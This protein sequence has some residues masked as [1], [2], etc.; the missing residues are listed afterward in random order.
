MSRIEQLLNERILVLDG[1]MGSMVQQFKLGEADYRGERFKNSPKDLKG[2]NDLLVL[3]R[4]DIIRSIHLDYL[5]AGADLIETNTFN[6]TS[7]AQKD[8]G[9]E[10]IVYEL[11]KT[12]AALAKEACRLVMEEAK[13]A[14]KPRECFVAGA[15]GPTNKT[16]SLSTDVN[17]PEFRAV[18]FDELKDAYYEQIEGLVDGGSDVLLFETTFDTLNLK[19][20]IFAYQDYNERNP[21]K[22]LPLMLSATI[23]DQSGRTLSGQTIEAFWTSVAHAKPVSVGI[24]CALGAR[25]M[26]PFIAALSD[27]ADC[28]ISCYPNAG[29]PNPLAPTGYD[30][31]PEMLSGTLREYAKEGLLNIVGGCCGTTPAHIKA[32]AETVRNYRPRNAL[33]SH[34]T[35]VLALS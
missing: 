19:A 20:A 22:K 7:I 10:A 2:N 17:R 31:T 15:V 27:L 26:R 35:E 9:L 8:Y 4:P 12:A 11:N 24:N 5:R 25:E 16:A 30:E 6:G 29:L 21:T 23:T 34:P 18:T 28:A 32:I 1:A 3:T 14:G 33:P 13:A